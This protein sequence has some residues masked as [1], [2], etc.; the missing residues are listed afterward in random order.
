MLNKT[1][2]CI[3]RGSGLRR[4]SETFASARI[5]ATCRVQRRIYYTEY[6]RVVPLQW[7]HVEPAILPR[8][9]LASKNHVHM[10]NSADWINQLRVRTSYPHEFSIFTAPK[11]HDAHN[12]RGATESYLDIDS[13]LISST[14][15]SEASP[16]QTPIPYI[17][18][19]H[20][21]LSVHGQSHILALSYVIISM[22]C[23]TATFHSH[24]CR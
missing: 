11:F 14:R 23:F 17:K 1:E 24:P 19:T 13:V 6:S 12:L 3:R 15:Y 16:K 7:Y 10:T 9:Y 5:S 22:G 21:R 4:D 2:A 20:E 18:S 8:H